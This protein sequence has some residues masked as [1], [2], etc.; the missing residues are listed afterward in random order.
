[1]TGWKAGPTKPNRPVKVFCH[2]CAAPANERRAD[3]RAATGA[4]ALF[5][6]LP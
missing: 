6:D 4:E 3:L 1:M 2:V 5:F